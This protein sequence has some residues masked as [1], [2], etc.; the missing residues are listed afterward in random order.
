MMSTRLLEICRESKQIYIK[1]IVRQVGYLL[2]EWNRV[3]R[4]VGTYNSN[5]GESPKRKNYI[6]NPNL[7]VAAN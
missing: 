1:G 4:N 2:E 7:S 5:A 6:N 3:F